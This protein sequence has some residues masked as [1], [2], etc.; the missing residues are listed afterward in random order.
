MGSILYPDVNGV[1]ASHV[2]LELVAH[3]LR[4]AG[5]KSLNWRTNHE[6]PKIRGTSSKTIG[7]TRGTEEH[8]GDVELYQADW[9]R[10]LLALGDGFAEK[11]VFV[12]A[13]YYEAA[14]PADLI[15]V[16]FAGTRF[17]SP[18]ESSSEGAEAASVKLSMSIMEI[19]RNG[20]QG[21]RAR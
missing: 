12:K 5:V 14:S 19:K 6:I 1:R 11:S 15:L 10:L 8:E 18:D 3:G 7:R 16:E 21:L 13:V 4:L 17:H 9:K 20:K 2:S